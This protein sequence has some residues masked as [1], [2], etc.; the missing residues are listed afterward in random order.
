MTSWSLCFLANKGGIN[1]PI[2]QELHTWKSILFNK[3]PPVAITLVVLWVRTGRSSFPRLT[4]FPPPIPVN[5][6]LSGHADLPWWTP[7]AGHGQPL[8]V[9]RSW[10]QERRPF[11]F[12]WRLP[13]REGLVVSRTPTI[14]RGAFL[15]SGSDRG[16][17][18]VW[19]RPGAP[20]MGRESWREKETRQ[21]APEA[22]EFPTYLSL[23]S[24]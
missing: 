2:S 7:T 11:S 17:V 6:A 23:S 18:G 21:G 10:P 19:L 3:W 15:Q 14:P 13:T 22:M 4:S 16:G 20:G 5:P 12:G 9:G 24:P 1:G 8:E